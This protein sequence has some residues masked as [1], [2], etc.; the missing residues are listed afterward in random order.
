MLPS[1][2]SQ[3][4]SLVVQVSGGALARKKAASTRQ[5]RSI[6]DTGK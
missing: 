6:T 5:S 3:G 2:R 1:G 4:C